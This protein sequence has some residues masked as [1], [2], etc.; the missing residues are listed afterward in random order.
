MQVINEKRWSKN[1]NGKFGNITGQRF[2]KLFVVKYAK[3]IKNRRYWLCQCDCGGE[4]LVNTADLR[5][6][7]VISCGCVFKDNLKK[8]GKHLKNVIGENHPSWNGGVTF[9]NAVV[10]SL[11]RAAKKRGYKW[12]LTDTEVLIL[13]SKNCF[14][15]NTSPQNRKFEKSYKGHLKPF[16]YN[17]IDRIDNTKGYLFDNVV[18]C[19]KKCNIAKGE[20]NL[21]EWKEHMEK[22][23][24]RWPIYISQLEERLQKLEEKIK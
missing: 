23:L 17:G 10:R 22:I 3:K 1:P 16:I 7:H 13:M 11:K 5:A 2:G 8:I 4:K 18:P 6:K 21:N 9:K 20:M 19:C 12:E 24:Q 14:Y 15:C